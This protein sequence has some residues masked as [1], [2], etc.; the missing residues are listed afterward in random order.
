MNNPSN[1]IKKATLIFSFAFIFVGCQ[2][3]EV[4]PEINANEEVEEQNVEESQTGTNLSVTYQVPTPNELF[5]LFN[6]V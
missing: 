5:T 3:S 2:N 1:I 4:N 6:D